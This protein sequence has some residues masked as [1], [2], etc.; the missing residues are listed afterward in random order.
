M[1][2]PVRVHEARCLD[3]LQSQFFFKDDFIGD[4]LQ[5]I[6]NSQGDVGGS[7]VVVDGETG[8]VVRIT[9]D[10]DT[11]DDWQI[12]WGNTQILLA[13]K[14][15]SFETNIK[16]NSITQV[17]VFIVVEN[18]GS[19]RLFSFT[20]DSSTDTNWQIQCINTATTEADTG[21][22]VDTDAHIFR[23]VCHTH[24]SAHVHFYIDNVETAN[25]PITTNVPVAYGEPVLYLLT[26]ENVAKSMDVDYVSI[27]QDR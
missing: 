15:C 11:N 23:A 26:L 17:L 27:R 24:G 20:Y 10:G 14:R 25:S 12:N 6:W 2:A 8:G 7:A 16:L 13:S 18:N 3:S 1:S 9:T 19:N 22:A 4:Q 5:D 21:I